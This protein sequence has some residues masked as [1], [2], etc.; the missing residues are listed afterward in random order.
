MQ[1]ARSRCPVCCVFCLWG[2][3]A[4][5]QPRSAS[6]HAFPKGRLAATTNTWN[7]PVR[8]ALR[9]RVLSLS[10]N[11]M[12]TYGSHPQACARC[13]R[14]AR[15]CRS[16]KRP[17]ERTGMGGLVP[18][19]RTFQERTGWFP[20]YEPGGSFHPWLLF[21]G[22][23]LTFGKKSSD[24]KAKHST[25]CAE[26]PRNVKLAE[27]SWAVSHRTNLRQGRVGPYPSLPRSLLTSRAFRNL[28]SGK[29]GR[30]CKCICSCMGSRSSRSAIISSSTGRQQRSRPR[31]S[32]S[33]ST[34]PS[35]GQ[36]PT[37]K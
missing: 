30:E 9:A 23:C 26:S 35:E 28:F 7:P 33:R 11:T 37:E 16:F 34:V 20:P 21:S 15:T 2:R 3:C 32:Q 24:R 36:P 19:L 27:T 10:L 4:V 25:T 13:P 18:T 29:P 31:N 6:A 1:Q 14:A 12:G 5:A 22:V 8:L 17:A